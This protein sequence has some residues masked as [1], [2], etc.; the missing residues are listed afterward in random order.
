MGTQILLVPC[1]NSCPADPFPC[2]YLTVMNLTS[3]VS[4]ETINS[5]WSTMNCSFDI[6][7]L[8][9]ASFKPPPTKDLILLSGCP[10]PPPPQGN[11]Q[12]SSGR[13]KRQAP[14]G[15]PK[16]SPPPVAS[17]FNTSAVFL[18]QYM[19]LSDEDKIAIGHR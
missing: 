15:K 14:G 5:A 17:D 11:N 19:D 9:Q 1:Y 10:Q 13:K 8:Y 18:R 7:C 12:Q 4:K 3:N 2:Y 6:A 16:N